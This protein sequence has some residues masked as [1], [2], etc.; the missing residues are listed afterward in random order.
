MHMAI[1]R[2]SAPL[3]LGRA[4]RPT[5][6]AYLPPA[7]PG[8]V[9]ARPWNGGITRRWSAPRRANSA[10]D[11]RAHHHDPVLEISDVGLRS[12]NGSAG[13]AGP[14]KPHAPARGAQRKCAGSVEDEAW[15]LLQ[16]SMVRYCGSP[17]GTIAACEPDDASPLNYDQVFIRDFVP[18][19]VAFLLKGEYDIVRNFILHTLQLQVR[20]RI[21]VPSVPVPCLCQSANTNVP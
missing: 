20:F 15:E 17:V 21:V 19:G 5:G 6:A 7:L 4:S 16:E 2:V 10:P 18:S 13:A 9:A 1:A 11:P 12:A 8:P 14:A 3:H